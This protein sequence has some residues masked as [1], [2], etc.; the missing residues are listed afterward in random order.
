MLTPLGA[1]L[2]LA[3]PL[4][5][6]GGG[7]VDPLDLLGTAARET[8]GRLQDSGS[9][10]ERLA[11][12]EQ[13]VGRRIAASRPVP[14]DLVWACRRIKLDAGRTSVGALATAI[15]CSRKHLTTRFRREFGMAPKLLARVLRFSHA[16]HVLARG[17]VESWAELALDCGYADQ[18]HLSREFREFA[19]SPPAA[20]SSRQLPDEGGLVD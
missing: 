12:L 8:I 7:L 3:L 11:I 6:V 2:L 1:R 14:R 15:G 10:I 16:L 5:E 19:G 20:F 13:T 9:A 18:A 4:D 17:P